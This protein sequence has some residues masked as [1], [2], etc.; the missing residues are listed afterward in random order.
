[1]STSSRPAPESFLVVGTNQGQTVP[2]W[3]YSFR[4]LSSSLLFVDK[5]RVQF[6][7]IDWMPMCVPQ[8]LAVDALRHV[9]AVLDDPHGLLYIE[10]SEYE[11]VGDYLEPWDSLALQ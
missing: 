5:A 1:M 4:T 3:F 11:F 6:P 10:P 8:D 2:T 9:Q 7:S